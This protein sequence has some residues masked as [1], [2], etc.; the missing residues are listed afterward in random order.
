[1]TL[2]AKLISA[3]SA[4]FSVAAMAALPMGLNC[5][6]KIKIVAA[7]VGEVGEYEVQKGMQKE[8]H[9]ALLKRKTVAPVDACH[10]PDLLPGQT[11]VARYTGEEADSTQVQCIDQNNNNAPVVFPKSI[12]TVRNSNISPH[13]LNP[14]CPDGASAD[15]FPCSK[16]LSQSE[17]GSEYKDSAMKWKENNPKTKQHKVD[18]VFDAAYVAKTPPFAPSV[19]NGAKLFCALVTKSGQVVMAATAQYPGAAG[20]QN[21]APAG[22]KDKNAAA[23][24]DAA[25]AATTA[26]AA[27]TAAATAPA[28][29]APAVPTAPTNPKDAAKA[30]VLGVFKK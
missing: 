12:F 3:S 11:V 10:F 14:Y 30:A 27:A 7:E 25:P 16:L 24:S 2:C 19:P 22:A 28:P 26:I 29:A 18:M 15:G 17:R 8:K 5:E 1:M 6:P 13:Y 20:A 21:A 9:T 4:L 23:G